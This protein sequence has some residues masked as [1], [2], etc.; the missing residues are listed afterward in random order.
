M[1]VDP[2]TVRCAV[3]PFMIYGE[4]VQRWRLSKGVKLLKWP[5]DIGARTRPLSCCSRGKHASRTCAG[6]HAVHYNSGG[7]VMCWLSTHECHR[8]ASSHQR[9]A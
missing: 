7:V 2:A 6:V 3:C 9:H 4:L 5:H 8:Q 1:H